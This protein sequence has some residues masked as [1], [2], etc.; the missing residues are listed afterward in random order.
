MRLIALEATLAP[1]QFRVL[2]FVEEFDNPAVLTTLTVSA[3]EPFLFAIFQVTTELEGFDNLRVT[4][5]PEPMSIAMF[6]TGLLCLLF[7]RRPRRDL[8]I[9]ALARNQRSS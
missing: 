8:G 9:A 4:F 6:G 2:S 3:A 1:D 7:T 5:V